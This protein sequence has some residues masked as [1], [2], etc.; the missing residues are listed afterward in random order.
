M[1]DL[2]S[3]CFLLLWMIVFF[4]FFFWK[5]MKLILFEK[6]LLFLD[7]FCCKIPINSEKTAIFAPY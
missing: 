6:K 7:K 3:F 2:K 4:L 1:L 5:D